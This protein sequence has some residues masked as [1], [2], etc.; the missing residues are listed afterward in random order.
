MI[1]EKILVEESV[2]L[3]EADEAPPA[4]AEVLPAAAEIPRPAPEEAPTPRSST[5]PPRSPA[6]PPP[7]GSGTPDSGAE[8]INQGA[9]RILVVEDDPDTR[10]LLARLLENAGFE[11]LLAED[12]VDALLKL[13]RNPVDLILSDINMP[14]LDGLKLLEIVNQ[15]GSNAPVVFLTAESD[16]EVELQGL[17][18]GAA[19]FIRKPIQ[20]EVLMHRVRKVLER[21]DDPRAT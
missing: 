7:V 10:T 6:S 21:R 8:A 12:G 18:M 17:Q 19:D 2:A 16:P 1:Y 11:V 13:G 5:P 3:R 14:N 4:A 9:T 15:H 20:K